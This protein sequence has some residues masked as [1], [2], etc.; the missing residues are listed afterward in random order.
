MSAYL[1]EEL[2]KYS[3]GCATGIFRESLTYK[4][5]STAC[6]ILKI[7]IREKTGK[8]S[9]T[10][11]SLI[12]DNGVQGHGKERRSLRRGGGVDLVVQGGSLAVVSL[13]SSC[14]ALLFHFGVCAGITC[15]AHSTH[16]T[17]KGGVIQC[18]AAL[19]WRTRLCGSAPVGVVT[20]SGQR[21]TSIALKTGDPLSRGK[22]LEL[23]D[24]AQALS[25]WQK[26]MADKLAMRSQHGKR[27]AFGRTRLGVYVL[28]HSLAHNT[29]TRRGTPD[30]AVRRWRAL[31]TACPRT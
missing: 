1:A 26:L 24:G 29:P 14:C 7:L 20:V 22:T 6:T 5:Y 19:G 18:P 13:S 15:R 27:E 16:P 4:T 12:R 30:H 17:D 21:L 25:I 3:K 11:R 2:A 31:T 8:L 10:A 23:L 9:G 28:V